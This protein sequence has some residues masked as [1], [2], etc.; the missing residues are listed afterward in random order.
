MAIEKPMVTVTEIIPEN[1]QALAAAGFN[2]AELLAS[3]G[4]SAHIGRPAPMLDDCLR[5]VTAKSTSVFFLRWKGSKIPRGAVIR[6]RVVAWTQNGVVTDEKGEM[7]GTYSRL[8]EFGP[9]NEQ[10]MVVY[11]IG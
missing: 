4:P 5:A 8:V 6:G 7:I 1:W 11:C 2:Q 3:E 10:Q 9:E